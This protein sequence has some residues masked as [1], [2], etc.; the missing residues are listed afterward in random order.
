MK[1]KQLYILFVSFKSEI[2]NMYLKYFDLKIGNTRTVIVPH[3]SFL[4][5]SLNFIFIY[6]VLRRMFL[7]IIF[8]ALSYILSYLNNTEINV[9]LIFK[10]NFCL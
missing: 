9:K 7:G 4:V 3:Y 2:I 6:D 8:I 1:L 10:P 5:G